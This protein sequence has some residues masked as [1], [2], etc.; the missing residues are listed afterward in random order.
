[1]CSHE[2]RIF[3]SLAAVIFISW[4]SSFLDLFVCLFWV[5]CFVSFLRFCF[6]MVCF[7]VVW[8]GCLVVDVFGWLDAWMLGC[9]VSAVWW[10]FVCLLVCLSVCCLFVCLSVCLFVCLFVCLSVCVCLFLVFNEPLH[11]IGQPRWAQT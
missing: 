1:M 4:I 2:H 3:L 10:F 5:C 7:A 9:L 6:G 11:G 8:F